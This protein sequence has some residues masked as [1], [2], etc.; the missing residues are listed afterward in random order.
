MTRAAV[1]GATGAVGQRFVNL[2]ADHPHFTLESVAASKRSAGKTY[3]AAD[4]ILDEEIPDAARDLEVQLASE[5]LDADVAFSALPGGEAEPVERGLASRGV[6]VFSN[7]R[8]LRQAEDVP[9]VIPE[10]NPDHAALVDE[11]DGDGFVV[12]NP[13]CS[14]IV[15]TLPLAPVDDAW[16]IESLRVTTYQAVSGAG[17]PGVP[18]LDILGNVVPRIGGEED[19]IKREPRRVLGTYRDGAVH[20]ASFTTAATAARVPVQEGHLMSVSVGLRDEATPGEVEAAL[21]AFQGPPQERSLPSAPDSPVHVRPEADRP[22]PDPDWRLEDGMAVAV[23][24]VREDPLLDVQ[25]VAC[26]SNTIRG[27]AGGSLL[28]A[29][30]FADRGEI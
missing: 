15:A 19:K 21:E 14:A 22:Q 2:L 25:F 6:K 10:V 4:W 13:N 23:G 7:A 1:L 16:G 9:L 17:Y 8:D 30:L 5:D 12:C 27:A 29:E 11:Q 26:G 18:S 3:K 20:R 24:R 28:N